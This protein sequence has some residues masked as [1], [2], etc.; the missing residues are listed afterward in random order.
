MTAFIISGEISSSGFHCWRAWKPSALAYSTDLRIM[1]GVTR[2]GTHLSRVTHTRLN[3]MNQ[4]GI[5]TKHQ[6]PIP[7]LLFFRIRSVFAAN[8][9][10]FRHS[11]LDPESPV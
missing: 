3:T 7:L 6:Y 5:R 9:V 2:T 10:P 11:G 4:N 1:S 8:P